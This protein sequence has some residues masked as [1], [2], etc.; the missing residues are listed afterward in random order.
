MPIAAMGWSACRRV[1][2]GDAELMFVDMIAVQMVE[3][4]VMQIIGVTIMDHGRMSAVRSMLMGMMLM[5]GMVFHRKTPFVSRDGPDC[6]L[7]V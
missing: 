7:K 3:V 1:L 6:L 2:C 4:S 5:D